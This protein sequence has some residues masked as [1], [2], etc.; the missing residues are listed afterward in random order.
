[1]PGNNDYRDLD[2]FSLI[3]KSFQMK[4]LFLFTLLFLLTNLVG[5]QT[6]TTVASV[7]WTSTST[8]DAN[9][10]PPATI[11]AGASV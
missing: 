4:N 5:A 6:Y 8:W 9:G 11:P 1:M 10:V 7:S 3:F 2:F